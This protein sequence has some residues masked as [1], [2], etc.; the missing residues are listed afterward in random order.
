MSPRILLPLSLL[1]GLAAAPAAAQT[2]QGRAVDRESLRP[3]SGAMIQLVDSLGE[4]VAAA[5]TDAGGAFRVTA[6]AA[7]EYAVIAGRTGFRG[8]VTRLVPLQ[9]GETVAVEVRMVVQPVAAAAPDAPRPTR[10]GITGRLVDDRTGQPVA[11]GR[12]TLLTAREQRLATATTDAAGTFHLD[13]AQAGGYVLRAER[14]GY[15]GTQSAILTLT[16][17]DTVAVE[18]RVGSDAVLLAPLTVVAGSQRMLRDYHLAGFQWR[19]ETQPFGR[20]MGRE[21]IKQLNPYYATDVLQQM[22]TVRVQGGGH[23]RTI[24]LSARGRRGASVCRPNIYVDGLLVRNVDGSTLTVNE[25]VRGSN[26]AGVEVYTSPSMAPGEF[27]PLENPD[28]GVVVLWT[29]LVSRT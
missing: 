21:Q 13:V 1:L 7:G 18:L 20:Y 19:S 22:P 27:Q 26:L 24:L 14:V 2:L 4:P 25:L 3:V 9:V 8:T 23:N 11:E 29:E 6:P 16:P 17:R 15:Q 10:P 5:V 28:C 12:V